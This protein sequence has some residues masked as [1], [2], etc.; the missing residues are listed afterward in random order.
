MLEDQYAKRI[1]K[2]NLHFVM[3]TMAKRKFQFILI[4]LLRS[5]L[6]PED[7]TRQHDLF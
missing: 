2:Q 1:P 7:V 3:G 6:S 4:G 5:P